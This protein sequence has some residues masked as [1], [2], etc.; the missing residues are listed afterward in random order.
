MQRTFVAIGCAL[1]FAAGGAL[2][3]QPQQDTGASASAN[4]SGASIGDK[5]KHAAHEVG[6]RTKQAAHEVGQA[7]K[8]VARDTKDKTKEIAHKVKPKSD[9]RQASN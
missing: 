9:E 2:A 3:Q 7:A 6:D 4:L 1:A 8:Q 5:V